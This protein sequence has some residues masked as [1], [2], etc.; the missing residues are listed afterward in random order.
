MAV[1]T[2]EDGSTEAARKIYGDDFVR[3]ES[4][5]HLSDAVGTLLQRKI[6][7]FTS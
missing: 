4:I 2:G 3:I 6:E 7:Q 1:L 5:R